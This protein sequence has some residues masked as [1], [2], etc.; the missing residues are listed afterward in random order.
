MQIGP[1]TLVAQTFTTRPAKNYDAE[2]V[3]IEVLKNG[4]SLMMLYPERRYYPANDVTGTMV[5]IHSTLKEDLYVVYAG[6]DPESRQAVI[7]AYV[8]PLVKWIWLG[9]VVLVLG[10][11]LALVPNREPVLALKG[12]VAPV[13]VPAAQ[14]AAQAVPAGIHRTRTHE[15]AD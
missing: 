11:G 7:H 13:G 12:A 14:G 15:S 8:N 1:Y 10:T 6:R 4:Q 3:T 2:R 9:G 5:S